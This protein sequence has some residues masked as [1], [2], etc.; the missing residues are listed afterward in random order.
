MN[1][2]FV[3]L[4]DLDANYLIPLEDKLTEELCDQA[5][6]EVITD[7]EYFDIFFSKPRKIDTLIISSELFSHDL[8][9]H[10][11]TDFFVL[12]EDP[13]D[14]QSSDNIS[15]I[16][17]YSSTKEI[18]NQVLYKNKEMSNVQISNKETQ[19]IVVTSGIGGSGKTTV[20][21]ALSERI[22]SNH[23]RVLYI[24][25]DVMQGFSYYLQNK[26]F[27]PN[28]VIRIFNGP[29][30]KLFSGIMPY[31]CNE[32]F[33]YLPPF[34]HS[35]LSIGLD[36]KIYNRFIAAV[37]KTK[38]YDYIVVDTDM[39]LDTAKAELM[40]IADK[41]IINV[42]QDSYSTHE[43]EF[44]IRNM[45]CTNREKFIFVCNKFRRDM[46]NEYMSSEIGKQFIIA[47]YIDEVPL[48]KIHSLD[49]FT[50]LS[51]IKNLG[52]IFS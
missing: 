42:L 24:S 1:K 31:L 51:G 40:Q 25:T 3:V 46:N 49:S 22:A 11:I 6:I 9:K 12:T 41:V 28:D 39:N 16:F 47:E 35:I 23:K 30:D 5:E 14:T 17:K 32:G 38:E 20:S 7:K 26:G 29:D 50:E 15:H 10:N 21:L 4:A 19:I 52:Y 45:D 27:L 33:T 48:H 13:S 34:C 44:L 8:I 37:K 43:T 36:N 18:F 2:P